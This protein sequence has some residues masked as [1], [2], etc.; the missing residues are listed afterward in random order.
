MIDKPQSTGNVNE[1]IIDMKVPDVLITQTLCSMKLPKPVKHLR[2]ECH[3]GFIV[4]SIA[5]QTSIITKT[6]D[7]KLEITSVKLD[8]DELIIVFRDLGRNS[9]V[10][11]GALQLMGIKTLFGAVF[12]DDMISVDLSDKWQS[13]IR[14]NTFL[15]HA[16]YDVSM[17]SYS[18]I[19]HHILVKLSNI[20]QG[21]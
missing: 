20:T 3:E 6:I 4:V 16:F 15:N 19:K 12:H 17:T 8:S 14:N 11:T 5:L 9:R 10:V 13:I 18:I 7:L 21:D 1:F 2:V